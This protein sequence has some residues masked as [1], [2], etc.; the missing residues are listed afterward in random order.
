MNIYNLHIYFLQVSREENTKGAAPVND[1]LVNHVRDSKVNEETSKGSEDTVE[2]PIVQILPKELDTES[3]GAQI[4]PE[5]SKNETPVVQIIP[6]EPDSETPVV[7][8]TPEEPDLETPIVRIV[9]ENPDNEKLVVHVVPEKPDNK[10][11]LVEITPEEPN[12]ETP[13]IQ[14]VPENPD[15]ERS[16]VQILPEGSDAENFDQTFDNIEAGEKESPDEGMALI[17]Q[18]DHYFFSTL[19][20]KVPNK[21]FDGFST[22]LNEGNP[23]G[24]HVQ[25]IWKMP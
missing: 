1:T 3:P 20:K 9:S 16:V 13:I 17:F 19:K 24:M 18:S 11:A 21:H 7:Q 23:S 8:V 12:I 5:K 10:T 15:I 6:E 2:E 4:I 25:V 14:I 22:I